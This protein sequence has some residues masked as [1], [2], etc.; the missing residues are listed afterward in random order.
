[1]QRSSDPIKVDGQLQRILVGAEAAH[2]QAI[3][4]ERGSAHSSLISPPLQC[5][6]T[7]SGSDTSQSHTVEEWL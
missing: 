4:M 1:M 5:L 7:P 3:G 2:N 6:E